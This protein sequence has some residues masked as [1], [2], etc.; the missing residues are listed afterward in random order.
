MAWFPISKVPIQFVDSNGD[1]YSGAVLKFS[2]AGTT[3]N[4]SI[5]TDSTGGTTATS[6]ALNASGFPEI[7]GSE[8]IPHVEE[9]YKLA[10]YPDQASADADS[11]AL[12]TY[13]NQIV[14]TV[15]TLKIT[16]GPSVPSDNAALVIAGTNAIAA[17][18]E[19]DNTGPSVAP[20][21]VLRK[22]QT[23]TPADADVAGV[24]SFA[25][26]DDGNN[27]TTYARIVGFAEDVTDTE[28][29]G[30]IKIQALLANTMTNIAQF[31]GTTG[32]YL[33]LDL[34]A[35]VR[36]EAAQNTGTVSTQ[37]GAITV[38]VGGTTKYIPLYTT[39]S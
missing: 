19:S 23:N 28:E 29:D 22:D 2:S 8:I 4:I 3:S 10:V 32:A 1:P 17:I 7:S 39:L 18:F 30:S 12:R 14:E 16:I 20:S 36:F 25:A 5:A 21:I 27:A 9:D 11:G 6:T 38:N 35:D 13:D 24:I 15:A 31:G 33:T 34:N 37:A 26:D